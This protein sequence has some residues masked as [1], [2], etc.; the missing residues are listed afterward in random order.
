MSFDVAIIGGGLAGL[1][2]ATYL[3]QNGIKTLVLEKQ[4]YPK[5]KVCGEYVSNEVLPFLNSLDF[6]PFAFGAKAIDKFLLTT[7]KGK[8]IQAK[9]SMGGFSLSRFAFDAA[10][11]QRAQDAGVNIVQDTVIST[12]YDDNLCHI[13]TKKGVTKT[14]KILIGAYGKRSNL[15]KYLNRKF[16]NNN[17]AYLAIKAHFKSDFQDGLVAL[18]NFNGGYCGL[19]KV[20]NDHVNVCYITNYKSF[21]KYKSISNFQ[22]QVVC[23]NPHLKAFLT[24]RNRFL[25]I[26]LVS[27]N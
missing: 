27:V 20:E 22:A 3:A 5:H 14:S 23:Q 10:L 18:H 7:V 16:L 9:L 2:A 8:R 25:R 21:K 4:A 19:S 11:A 26:R 12:D 24:K 13:T 6:D 17:S 1:S 15:D